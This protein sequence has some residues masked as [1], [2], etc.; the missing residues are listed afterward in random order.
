MRRQLHFQIPIAIAVVF[1]LG[2]LWIA[3]RSIH[4]AGEAEKTLHAV[5]ATAN[6]LEDFVASQKRWPTSWDD[7]AKNSKPISG[8]M[9]ELP[10]DVDIV[11][12]RVSVRFDLPL[13]RL[14]NPE[15]K[16][17]IEPIGPC[18]EYER[19]LSGMYAQIEKNSRKKS[20]KP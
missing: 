9:Y 18:F 11:R 1:A 3:A 7:L 19:R 20:V 13:E 8:S 16:G 15:G 6:A 5:I 17:L 14:S 4:Y 10:R 2:G 12:R